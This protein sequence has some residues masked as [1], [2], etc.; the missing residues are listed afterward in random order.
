MTKRANEDVVGAH[1][2]P[3]ARTSANIRHYFRES[4]KDGGDL[5]RAEVRDLVLKHAQY[6]EAKPSIAHPCENGCECVVN[7]DERCDTCNRLTCSNCRH[8]FSLCSGDFS[9]KQ[10][11]SHSCISYA[12]KS[13]DKINHS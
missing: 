1:G 11:C 5:S 13:F 8:E 9:R 10:Y 7:E 2:L 6:T 4:K 3:F 12:T